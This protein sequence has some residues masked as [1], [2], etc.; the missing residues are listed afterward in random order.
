MYI[1]T[2]IMCVKGFT[3]L[4]PGLV[5]SDSNHNSMRNTVVLVFC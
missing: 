5:P 4:G 2:H 1:Y 3:V